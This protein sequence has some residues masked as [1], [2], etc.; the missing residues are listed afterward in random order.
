MKN[1]F[2]MIFIS[3][4]VVSCQNNFYNVDDFSSMR[5]IDSHVHINN[6]KG[7]FEDQAVK[8]N[9]KMITIN[10][11]FFGYVPVEKQHEYALLSLKK[12]PGRIFYEASFN[13]DTAGWGTN[14]WSKKVITGLENDISGGAVGVKLWRD[15]GMIQKDRNGKFIMPD[16][17]GLE[18]IISFIMSKNLPLTAHFAEPRDCW[19]PLAKMDIKTDSSYFVQNPQYHMFLHPECPSYEQLIT[20]RDHLVATHP[21]LKFIGCHFGS[22]E[23]NVDSLA[24]RLDKFPNMVVDMAAK[25]CHMQYQ[26]AKDRKRVRD[27]CIKYQDRLLYATDLD[28]NDKTDKD[29]LQKWIHETWLNDWKYFAT[30]TEMTTTKF[31]GKFEGLQLPKKV[32]D[33]IYRENAIKWYKLKIE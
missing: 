33:K 23:W 21:D 30:K 15:I 26:S 11:D 3:V 13:F 27:F 10:V 14:E 32:I 4:L 22:I 16:D 12:Y 29:V 7:Y 9:F 1:T 20:A 28:D 6:D 25:I 31:N 8:D 19:L 5:K 2:F 17:P 24:K 18:P